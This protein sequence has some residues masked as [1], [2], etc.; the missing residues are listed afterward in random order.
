LLASRKGIGPG[1]DLLRV[2]LAFSVVGWHSF[3]LADG[4]DSLVSVHFFWFPGYAILSMFFALSG[5]LITASAMR[6]PLADFLVNRSLRIVPALLVEV[7]LSAVVLGA[8][9]TTLP[10]SQY[11]QSYGFWRYFGN[12]AGLVTV[13][14]PGVFESNPSNSVNASLWTIPFEIGCYML[15]AVL[16][17]SKW[18]QRPRLVLALYAAFAIIGLGI[19]LT[20]PIAMAA[21]PDPP[22][23]FVGKGSRL[24]VSFLLGIAAYLYR[25]DIA[26]S[27]RLALVCLLLCVAFAAVGP[28]PSAV[29]N[30]VLAPLLVYLTVYI[31]VT[32]VP[33][34]PLF[35]RGDYSY[36][37]YLYGY[38]LQQ[39][40]VA[41]L[42]LH[43]NALLL[44]LISLPV[45]TGF[46][47]LSWHAIEHPILKLRR[48]LSFTAVARVQPA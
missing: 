33:K 27:H 46:A 5:F 10:L 28:L 32:D 14:L 47:M 29:L 42:P 4:A 19:Y 17:L 44:D 8:V 41:L 9:F 40:F 7:M 39:T 36:G 38:P 18:L 22:G 24:F 25:Y 37:I 12:I 2:G 21:S 15:M 1:F 26:Y 11:F 35:R 13:T 34:L 20:G 45:I 31:G 48:R 16:V 23:I 3:Y 6:L 43:G 30:I